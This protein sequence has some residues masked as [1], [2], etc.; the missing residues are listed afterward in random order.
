[1]S[2][3]ALVGAGRPTVRIR[4]TR[5][6]VL[7]PTLRDPRLHLAAVIVSLQVLGQTAFAFRLSI[8]QILVALLTCAVLEVGIAFWRRRVIM[9]PASALLTG[10]GVAFILRV[11]GTEHG[12]WWSLRGAW[13]FAGTSAVALLS[14][15]LIR[16][17]G[18]HIFNP[19]N[20]GLVLGFLLL[21]PELADPLE[22][23]WGPTSTWLVL[24]LTIIVAGGL[25]I[26]ARLRLL[27]IAVV[28][29][30]TFA[31]ALGVLAAAG[32]A[33]T[34]RWHLGPIADAEFWRVLVFSP[35]I[36]VFLFFMITDP[37]TVPDGRLGRRLYAASV[38][39]LAAL[40]I[41]PQK[42][43]FGSKVALLGALTLVCAARPLVERL[44]A[45]GAPAWA[46]R[47]LRGEGPGVAAMRTATALT[48]AAAAAGLLVLA[49]IPARSSAGAA[50][51]RATSAGG[52]PQV[53][54]G[55]SK[56]VA[57]R[58][59]PRTARQIAADV[60]AD[61]RAEA[62]ALRRR[63]TA[64]AAAGAGG[65]RLAALLRAIRAAGGRA[66]VVPDY[67][68][69]RMRVTLEPGKGQ[70]PP[71][72]VAALEGTVRQATYA[73]SA[74]AVAR[75]GDPARFAH[76]LELALVDGRY[77][78]VGSRGSAAAF[79]GTPAAETAAASG[80][81]GVRL[82]D[83]AAQV[84]L[85]FRQGAFRFGV[86]ADPV[87][88]MGGGLCWLDYDNDGWLDLFVVN[89]Y[90]E[91]DIGRWQ[92]QGGLPRSA[93]FHNVRGRFVDVSR[94]SGADLPLRGNGC[95][96]ADFDLDGR[97]DI[98]VTTGGYNVATDGYDALLW[99]NGDGTFS[100]GARAAGI[101]SSGWHAG[102]AVGDVNG[103]GRPDLFVAGYTDLNA[104]LPGSAAGF[105]TGYKGV[106]DRLYLNEGPAAGTR[107]RFREVGAQAGIEKAGI[108]H[109]LGA[110]FSDVNGDGRLDLYVAN[111]A[112]PNRLYENVPWPGGAAADPAGLG[113][114]LEE[115][116]RREGVADPNAGMG[117]ASADYSGDGRPDLFVT[118]SH[119]QLHA[120]YRSRGPRARGASFT[121]ARPGFASAFDTSL[122]GW[123]V[124]WV[125]LDLDGNPD[126]AVANGAIPVMNLAKDAEPI[127]VFE[128]LSGQ[129]QPG[130]F[131]D[132]GGLAGLRR[133]P[134]VNG[135]GLAAADFD[136]DGNVD[137]AVSSI[138]GRL[139]LL[140]STAPARHWLEVKLT[141]FS[142]GAVVTAVLP[143]G[144]RLVREVHAGSSYLSSED[145]RVHFGLGDAARVRE[146]RVRYPDG[147]ETR[148]A[149]VAS[150]QIV[151]VG[152]GR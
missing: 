2:A 26:L 106:R 14:K 71:T 84:G 54:V 99:N 41:A 89:S 119:G 13:I 82:T 105:P 148:L 52:L 29:W 128:N 51:A 59:D 25:V 9:W 12:D 116:A 108:E 81:A 101:T 85:D 70:A 127:Q 131:A 86:T 137:V 110:L 135:R 34:A 21:G 36:L 151:V 28:F 63:D 93:L 118:N 92:E 90:S 47:L 145:P 66:V 39:L 76:T 42:T 149:D 19:S 130:Q 4:G 69:E 114:R 91:L 48:A 125:D 79:P 88:M 74:P 3:P 55:P 140:R 37:K 97:T 83:V 67:H 15:H 6:P 5:Y 56:G 87:A 126:L 102:A 35:E 77:V 146:L 18:R 32:H 22:F 8:A 107:A 132:A 136:N 40:L 62:D 53:T 111:D 49:G 123:G 65:A 43:E 58:I 44:A 46:A 50:N 122:A 98:Y 31:A 38:A 78:I 143:D 72:V 104:P 142:P 64:R 11:P 10:N 1:M 17:R 121:D 33:M 150:N 73:G 20:V 100:E 112:D 27:G 103:D 7:L 96:A 139:V 134:R 95:V 120:V 124:S 23:W 30:L 45:R 94:G 80:F 147:R 68:V 144:R 152:R 115:R 61:L 24:A 113:F 57:T 60:V 138:G 133:L 117:I 141:T 16:V 129:G 75:R 109:G